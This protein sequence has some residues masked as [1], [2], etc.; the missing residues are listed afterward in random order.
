MELGFTTSLHGV[1][2]TYG[3]CIEADI[4]AACIGTQRHTLCVM[5]HISYY[6]V[7]SENYMKCNSPDVG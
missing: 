5:K 2:S 7:G 1:V 6:I 4:M 3:R